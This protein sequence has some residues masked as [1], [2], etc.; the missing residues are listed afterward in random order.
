[1]AMVWDGSQE[2]EWRMEK[3]GNTVS[4]LTRDARERERTASPATRMAKKLSP[5]DVEA[6]RADQESTQVELARQYNVSQATI[7][8]V[9]NR[10]TW[11]WLVTEDL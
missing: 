11:E 9:Q 1:M 2:R 10:R 5:A 6:I 4:G 3:K 8:H 7:S